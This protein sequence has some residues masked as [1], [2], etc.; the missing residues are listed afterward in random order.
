M[1]YGNQV[2]RWL[3]ISVALAVASLGTSSCFAA[4]EGAA[5][6]GAE[7]ILAVEA[8][9]VGA[10]ALVADL[11]A[12][13]ALSRFVVRTRGFGGA[14][15]IGTEGLASLELAVDD[16]A[17]SRIASSLE[18]AAGRRLRVRVGP[19][20]NVLLEDSP[21][22]FSADGNIVR[23]LPPGAPQIIGRVARSKLWEVDRAGVPR[24]A[25]ADIWSTA[26]AENIAVRAAG[27][28]TADV[29]STLRRSEA[30]D[31]VRARNGWFEVIVRAGRRGWVPAGALLLGIV[32]HKPGKAGASEEAVRLRL[33]D[34]VRILHENL[35][36]LPLF[37]F[38]RVAAIEAPAISIPQ[39][40]TVRGAN[41]ATSWVFVLR[42]CRVRGSSNI[43]DCPISI[44]ARDE[45]DLV[46][47]FGRS[48]TGPSISGRHYSA[49]PLSHGVDDQGTMHEIAAIAYDPSSALGDDFHGGLH[50][51][52][53]DPRHFRRGQIATLVL[54]MDS[55]SVSATRLARLTL[56]S[57]VATYG[58]KDIVA[59][60]RDVPIRREGV[61]APAPTWMMSIPDMPAQHAEAANI[62][63]TLHGCRDAPHRLVAC[64][65]TAVN[66]GKQGTITIRFLER[67]HLHGALSQED[68]THVYAQDG[69]DMEPYMIRFWSKVSH[70]EQ[71][72]S[73]SDSDASMEDGQ[74]LLLPDLPTEFT[75]VMDNSELEASRLRRIDLRFV[76]NA[77]TE[78]NG[79]AGAQS[80][81]TVS[82]KDIPIQRLGSQP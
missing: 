47:Y 20:G 59:D 4:I 57:A 58:F 35:Y 33:A 6:V 66:R 80:R 17:G 5:A 72:F 16:V 67:Q 32:P 25:V 12:E 28:S 78:R 77:P 74:Q 52:R 51:R 79:W 65:F 15:A 54:S 50:P 55:V 10:R 73:E 40:K 48:N 7:E 44:E 24:Y 61:R 19:T 26:R 29:L 34:S 22:S 14:G 30:V 62:E 49:E 63:V 21:L 68:V 81:S 23:T 8:A 39:R 36:P 31:I 27:S 3:L 37:P 75:L 18:R 42:E 56:I 69:A 46:L 43:V 60:F 82:F 70:A 1:S 53:P 38:E 13:G 9:S 41:S 11:A 71:L 76:M 45:S 2:R 64:D